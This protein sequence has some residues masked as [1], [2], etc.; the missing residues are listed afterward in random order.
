MTDF[1]RCRSTKVPKTVPSTAMKSM[2]EPPMI[3]VARTERVSK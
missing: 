1:L 2:N 3:E